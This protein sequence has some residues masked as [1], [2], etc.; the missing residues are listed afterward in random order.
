MAAYSNTMSREHGEYF[1]SHSFK[2][3]RLLPLEWKD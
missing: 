2:R 1:A 3:N